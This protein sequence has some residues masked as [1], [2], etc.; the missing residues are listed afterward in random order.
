MIS[1]ASLAMLRSTRRALRQESCELALKPL[2]YAPI[3]MTGEN[4]SIRQP[5]ANLQ[6]FQAQ[7]MASEVAKV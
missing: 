6:E 2:G 3:R 1:V 4:E 5:S 7:L